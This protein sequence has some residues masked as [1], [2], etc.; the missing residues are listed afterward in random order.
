MEAIFFGKDFNQGLSTI[1]SHYPHKLCQLHHGV[2]R[3]MVNLNFEV[4]QHFEDKPMHRKAKASS[5]ERLK[6]KQLPLQLWD[7]FG[8]W[9]VPLTIPKIPQALHLVHMA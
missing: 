7:L 5:E 6:N 2:R 4:L 3:E 8:S 1:R 9:S